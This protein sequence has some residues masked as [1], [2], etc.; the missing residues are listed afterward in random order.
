MGYTVNKYDAKPTAPIHALDYVGIADKDVAHTSRLNYDNAEIRDHQEVAILGERPSGPEKF[1]IASGTVSYGDIQHTDNMAL[2]EQED[3]R[4]KDISKTYQV[5]RDKNI[6]GVVD[7]EKIGMD[8]NI[9]GS[10]LEPE[11]LGQLLDNPY[12]NK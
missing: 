11:L 2:K 4:D 5:I 10:R 8:R 12:V 1:Q 3:D 9:Y 6:I 7:K